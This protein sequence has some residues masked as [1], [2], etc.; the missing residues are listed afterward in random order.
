MN[1][2]K[3]TSHNEEYQLYVVT[4]KG[5]LRVLYVPFQVMCLAENLNLK[6]GNYMYVEAISIHKEH[7]LI[8][9]ILGYWYPYNQFNIKIKF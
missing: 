7:I 3:C 1:L 4:L 9:R 6:L 5:Y 2:I 8:Y